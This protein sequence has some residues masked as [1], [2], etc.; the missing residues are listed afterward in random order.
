[1]SKQGGKGK[2]PPRSQR[3]LDDDEDDIDASQRPKMRTNLPEADLGDPLWVTYGVNPNLPFRAKVEKLLIGWE[4]DVDDIASA[5]GESDVDRVAQ[6]VAD[7]KASWASLGSGL[8]TEQRVIE[9]G[10][11]LS[12]LIDLKRQLEVL[13]ATSPDYKHLQLQVTILERMAKL[14]GIDVDKKEAE[15]TAKEDP[16]EK[17]INSLSPE[18]L[19]A[20][21]TR[22]SRPPGQSS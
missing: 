22:L 15:E 16:V 17:A 18:A 19:K 10:R 1:M 6:V 12:E 11:M 5:L 9:R 2:F 13:N 3:Y 20:L 14:R 7:V 8:S 4:L 21:H